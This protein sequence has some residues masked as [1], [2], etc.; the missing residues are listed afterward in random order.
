M[1]EKIF[2]RRDSRY[3]QYC[4]CVLWKGSSKQKIVFCVVFL[5]FYHIQAWHFL[6]ICCSLKVLRRISSLDKI[7][8]SELD[9]S[10]CLLI[11]Q[12]L[13][14][15]EPNVRVINLMVCALRLQRTNHKEW[16]NSHQM[17]WSLHTRWRASLQAEVPSMV[18]AHSHP[19][20]HSKQLL[21]VRMI[22]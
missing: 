22:I 1:S 20:L 2:V 8:I 12:K 14:I 13:V 18:E 19:Q 6:N 15:S 16:M 9:V 11:L 5:L 4:C 7:V 17:R 21:Q 10:I 3:P